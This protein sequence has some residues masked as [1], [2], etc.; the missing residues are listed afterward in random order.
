MAEH[1]QQQHILIVQI[2]IQYMSHKTNLRIVV[3][4]CDDLFPQFSRTDGIIPQ[5]FKPILQHLEQLR[6]VQILTLRQLIHLIVL[7]HTDNDRRDVKILF[8]LHITVFQ[9]TATHQSIDIRRVAQHLDLVQVQMV[10]NI[11]IIHTTRSLLHANTEQHSLLLCYAIALSQQFNFS[12]CLAEKLLTQFRIPRQFHHTLHRL[13][14][15]H[16]LFH[17]FCHITLLN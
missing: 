16:F 8:V 4:Q 15:R 2:K 6:A 9:Q 11:V 1:H 7:Q 13:Q 10:G 17:N 12:F 14:Q 3:E 5:V